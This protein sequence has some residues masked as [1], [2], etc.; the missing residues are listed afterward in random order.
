MK[1]VIVIG[2]GV[3]GLIAAR[4]CA[5]VG[6]SVT[7]L[8]ATGVPGG[9]LGSHEVAGLTLDSG[10]ESFAVRRNAVAEFIDD[11]GL[12]DEVVAPNPAGAWLQLPNDR[13]PNGSVSVPLPKAGVLGIPGSPLADD[14]RRVIG[15]SGAWRAYADRLMPVLTIGR[16]HSLGELVR[17]RM[18][19]RVLERLVEPVTTGVYS[20][21]A[22]DLEIDVV[23]PGLNSALTVTGSLSGAVLSLRSAAPA[24][25]NVAGL[26]G[27]MS[28]LVAALM[29]D[30][31]HF[32]VEIVTDA[33]VT[34]LHRA[35]IDDAPSWTVTRAP[36]ATETADRDAAAP[37][38]ATSGTNASA[39]EATLDAR[40][41]IIATPGAQA[42]G[43]MADLSPAHAA[44]AE[45]D[46]PQPTAIELATI[47][48]DAPALDAH[49]RGTGVLVAAA[50]PGVTAKALTHAT[51]KWEWLAEAAGPGRHVIRLSYGRAGQ[52]SPTARLSDD[53]LLALSLHDARTILGVDLDAE[54]VRGFARTVWADALSPAT[55]GAPGRV[56][57]V[58]EVVAA[59]P[60]LELTGAWLAGTGLA[61]VIP[62]AVAAAS[63]TRHDALGI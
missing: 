39:P 56:D 40:F 43:L 59:T 27:G 28:R 5:R 58:R 19:R 46:W 42:L 13:V 23:A 33:P 32:G 63:R 11:L 57:H 1:D 48:I 3:A 22:D 34:G 12:S 2:G 30:L 31:R 25:S 38:T 4:A 36:A 14:V 49:P 60:G 47:V 15:W 52:M 7:V 61:S 35:G 55:V 24:G 45:L 50:T 54:A 16:E 37:E 51:A 62:D 17:K 53:E 26:R 10:A 9:A 18:G 21:A 6:L 8:E 20:S 41:V 29:A 44:L